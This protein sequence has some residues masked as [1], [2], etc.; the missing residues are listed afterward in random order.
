MFC[1]CTGRVDYPTFSLCYKLFRARKELFNQR[2]IMA[3]IMHGLG[4]QPHKWPV[5][6]HLMTLTNRNKFWLLK[7][8][9]TKVMK[10]VPE[11]RNDSP[12]CTS[13]P[14]CFSSSRRRWISSFNSLISLALASSL[15]T[16]LQRMAFARSA[17]LKGYIQNYNTLYTHKK[18]KKK[19][20]QNKH[21]NKL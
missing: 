14:S 16:A 17:Y 6:I 21:K 7:K 5:K 19:T 8:T 11:R 2:Q 20:K 4:I 12:S 10:E 3:T 18:D 1:H 9:R 15:T 13:M